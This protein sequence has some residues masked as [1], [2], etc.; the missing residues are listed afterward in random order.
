MNEFMDI[1]RDRILAD[2]PFRVPEGYLASFEDRMMARIAAEEAEAS[3]E[4]RQR[5][6]WRILKPAFTLAAM[7]ALIFGMGYGVLSLTHTLNRGAGTAAEGYASAE[8]ELIRPVSLI[9]YY[10]SSNPVEDAGEIDEETLVSYLS[11]EL[12]FADLAD[13]YAQTFTE[14]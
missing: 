8:E 12:S 5:P 13:I 4:K 6:V 11:S 10:Q 9:N 14:K 7:F 2:N 3:Q 1:D